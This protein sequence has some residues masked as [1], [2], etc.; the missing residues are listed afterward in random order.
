MSFTKNN[1]SKSPIVDTVFIIARAAKDAVKNLGE[2][3]VVDATVGSFCTEDGKLATLDTVFETYQNLDP[4]QMAAYASSFTGNPDF[5]EKVVEWMKIP[6]DLYCEV[7]ATPGG[8]GAVDI[9]ISSTLDEGQT[10]IVPQI[11]WT[12]YALMASMN[13]LKLA[14]YSLFEGDHFDL[15]SFKK[16]CQETMK[17]QERLTIVINDPCHNPTGY[18]LSSEEWDEVISFL[19]ECS[20]THPVVLINDVAYIDFS[21]RADAKDY[22]QK[23]S[24]ISDNLAV[25]VAFSISKSMTSYG[26][27][28]G[29]AI[30]LAKTEAGVDEMKTVFEKQARAIWS[31]VNNGAMT[32]FVKV[33]DEKLPEYEAEKQ[34]YI[35]LLKQRADLFMK[36]ADEAELPYYPYKEGFFVTLKMNNE[37]R[38]KFHQAL[39]DENIYT[40][41]VNKGIRLAICS[42]PL[43]KIE[44]LAPRLKEIYV[45]AVKN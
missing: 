28:C 36:E 44:G 22:L 30:I 34:E 11:A 41:K 38:D 16:V 18:S 10:L 3:A 29:A 15:D 25:V 37:D 19:N 42:L 24:R 17:N 31:N 2:D 4:R 27:R 8:T 14:E 45:E 23:F 13:N 39:M 9:S 5:R 1:I 6:S 21:P 33:L 7:I 35:D 40:V 12:S 26:L 32:M 20:K 43:K